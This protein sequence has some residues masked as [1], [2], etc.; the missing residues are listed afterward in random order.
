MRRSRARR[1]R[2]RRARAGD[3]AGRAVGPCPGRCRRRPRAAGVPGVDGR[4]RHGRDPLHLRQHRASQGRRAQ[5]PQHA[6]RRRERGPLPRQHR[7]R[8]HPVGAAAELR[9]RAE[10]AHHGVLRGRPRGAA[11]LPAAARRAQAVREVRRHR[12]DLRASAVAPA[13]HR[14][15]ARGG[16]RVDALLRQHRRPDAARDPRTAAGDLPGREP[17]P[18]VRPHRGLPL[19]LPGPV[20]GR[21]APRLDRQGDPQ[22]GDPRRAAGRHAVRSGRGGRARPP[23]PARRHGLLGRRGADR[24]AFQAGA[25]SRVRLARAG[26][27]RL[28]RRPRRRRRGGLPLLRRPHRR[29]DQDQRLPGEPDGDRGGRLR[30]R[31]G[32][33]RGRARDAR[34]RAGAPHR[35]AREPLRR[36]R[37]PG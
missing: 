30:L 25:R 11:Q 9:R 8:R 2:R 16:D 3:R 29:H 36:D 31:A 35:A 24:R 12:P 19:D 15:L 14:R 4:P 20:A 33:R 10:P 6:G 28:V 21:R 37:R 22:R 13:G 26:A 27:G 5:P 32:H 1:A 23:R 17:V 18:D 34:P 7:G